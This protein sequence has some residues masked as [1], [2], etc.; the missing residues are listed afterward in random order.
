MLHAFVLAFVPLFIAI[1]APMAVPVFATMTAEVTPIRRKK[2]ADE[3]VIAALAVGFLFLIAGSTFFKFAGI[4]ENDF[5]I[6]GGLV[7]LVSSILQLSRNS[8][9]AAALAD[10]S[11]Q[12]IS[13]AS[14]LGIP[15][16]M[17]PASITTIIL[18]AKSY[19]YVSTFL[20]ISLNLLIVWL[21]F[22]NAKH[23]I[24]L[25]GAKNMN[26]IAKIASL[27]LVSIAVMMIR[28]G[29]HNFMNPVSYA[30]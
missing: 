14:P 12:A 15:L 20:S 27:V 9:P 16:V 25:I 19:G 29:I 21:A 28:V 3:A 23:L 2:V 7:L 22:R 30:N 26:V 11:G 10:E 24:A 6:G 18:A 5:R 1:D 13:G 17:G 4:T 8:R